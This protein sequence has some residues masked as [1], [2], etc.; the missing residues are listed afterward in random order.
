M[1]LTKR[2]NLINPSATLKIADKVK[3]L[4]RAG[5]NIIKLQTGEPHLPTPDYAKFA[6]IDALNDNQTYYSHSR[7]IYE[8]RAL[9]CQYY[10]KRYGTSFNAEEHVLI[11]PG[12]KQAILY[13]MLSAVEEG[14][15]VIIPIPGWV[16]YE[17]IVKIAGGN[18]IFVD[19]DEEEGFELPI[20]KIEESISDKTKVIIL[21]SPNNPTGKII[22]KE[23][24]E[25]VNQLCTKNDILLIGDEIYDRIV[26]NGK[27]YTSI[28]E[29]DPELKNCALINGF[30]K[31]YSMTGWRLGYVI[32][33]PALISA[34]TKLQQ[35]SATCPTTFAQYG[36]IEGLKSGEEFVKSAVAVYQENR[37][38]LLEE[39]NKLEN[40]RVTEPE[41]GLYAFIDI[42]KISTDSSEFCL[43]LLDRCKVAA[44][45]GIEFGSNSQHYI[46]ICLATEK[47]NIIE[48]ARRLKEN[49]G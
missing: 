46:R 6:A 1:K 42:S 49:Y 31:V 13:A 33:E 4:E 36:A 8:L 22:S 7:G 9:L 35:H 43:E 32:A 20:H 15:E 38:L 23:T 30:S 19:C 29:V 14:D 45:P 44:V 12:G 40:F 11:T 34:M 18:P 17:E 27:K 5:Q 2:V 48:F 41:G 25:Q 21:N 39:F 47:E 10:N 24:L 28:I 37:A 26:F 3:E 16:S